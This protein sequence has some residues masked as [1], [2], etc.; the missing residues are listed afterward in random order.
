MLRKREVAVERNIDRAVDEAARWSYRTRE[1]ARVVQ[2][3]VDLLPSRLGVADHR[4]ASQSGPPKRD[5]GCAMVPIEPLAKWIRHAAAAGDLDALVQVGVADNVSLDNGKYAG[6]VVPITTNNPAINVVRIWTWLLPAGR[7]GL[8]SG[9]C[10]PAVEGAAMA[11]RHRAM[12]ASSG[13]DHPDRQWLKA[14]LR[15]RRQP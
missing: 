14:A 5:D 13:D 11:R 15:M 2:Q 9:P 4:W 3:A 10:G 12:R 7:P 6:A 8:D 1:R